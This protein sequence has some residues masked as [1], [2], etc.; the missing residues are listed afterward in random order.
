MLIFSFV[1]FSNFNGG[2]GIEE[3]QKL[4]SKEYF[5]GIYNKKVFIWL[6]IYGKRLKKILNF[7]YNGIVDEMFSQL[8]M[9]GNEK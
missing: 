5:Q 7:I 9:N 8:P 1:Y 6:V 2:I 3:Q 4:L